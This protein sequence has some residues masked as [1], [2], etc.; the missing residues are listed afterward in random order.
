MHTVQVEEEGIM[1]N[2]CTVPFQLK[3]VSFFFILKLLT[4]FIWQ[5]KLLIGIIA[6]FTQWSKIPMVIQSIYGSIEQ[7]KGTNGK[8]LTFPH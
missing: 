3:Q 1:T 2:R 8:T 4:V 7:Y 5:E 6:K